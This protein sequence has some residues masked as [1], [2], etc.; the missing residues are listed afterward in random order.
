MTTELNQQKKYFWTPEELHNYYNNLKP[1][2]SFI[3]PNNVYCTKNFTWNEV[4]RTNNQYLKSKPSLEIL[5]NLKSTADVLQVYRE[6]I[7]KP[8]IITSSLR[9]KEEQENMKKAAIKN[10]TKGPSETSLHLEGLA[11][12]F[13]IPGADLKNVQDYLNKVHFGEVEYGN[14]YTH[15]SLPTFSKGYLKKKE[16]D[17]DKYYGKLMLEG[18]PQSDKIKKEITKRFNEQ[19][20]TLP[21]TFVRED[22]INL[23]KDKKIYFV[24]NIDK[25]DL[26]SLENRL[27]SKEEIARMDKNEYLKYKGNIEKQKLTTGIFTEKEAKEA[28]HSGRLIYVHSYVRR[29][30]TPVRGYFRTVR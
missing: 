10:K 23:F 11:L 5:N 30:G 26:F 13:V 8:I 7:G 29:D 4:L 6:K 3:L 19:Y 24:K 9:T 12:D 22:N 2:E 21:N 28:I 18:V 15:I 27:F 25:N 16:F 14:N 17:V 1:G 20:I